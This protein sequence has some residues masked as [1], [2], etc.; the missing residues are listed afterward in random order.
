LAKSGVDVTILEARNRVGGRIHTIHDPGLPI[1]VELGAEFV[2][3]KPPEIWEVVRQR[4]LVM[5][6]LEGDTWCSEN[7]A[8]KKCNDLWPR[9]EKVA[10]L[11]KRGRAYPDRSF[12][13]FID[14]LNLDPKTKLFATEFVEGFNAARADL[15]SLQYLSSAQERTDEVSGDTP[16]RMLNGLDQIVGWL[17]DSGRVRIH[18]NT[19]VNEIRW[20]PGHVAVNGFEADSAI[21]TLPLSILQ[22]GSV[23]FIPQLD[24]KNA[25]V[26]ELVMGHAV[27]VVLYFRSAF[28]EE[29]GLTNVSFLHARGE[30][31]P[32]WWTTRPVA[33]SILVGWAGGPAA[34]Q[35]AL[36]GDDYILAAAVES[37]AKALKMDARNIARRIRMSFVADW[38]TDPF[39]LGAYS[40][41][42]VNSITAPMA[43]AEPV[44]NTLF[45]AGEATNSDGDSGTIHGAIATGY[46][47][48]DELMSGMR[49]QAA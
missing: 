12:S 37:L 29:R 17:T 16:Y 9:W 47:A 32:T 15:I 43:L 30:R 25:A 11:L 5:G 3:G 27:K 21:V 8:L 42:P 36:R 45:F 1:P 10:A 48:A 22:S 33:T 26:R 46:R 18:L 28:W 44:A 39:T 7:R 40:Y 38:Q 13:E 34:E 41:V 20:R 2:H 35:V 24:E 4:N 31:F 19:P 49:R 14:T 23:R 6:S